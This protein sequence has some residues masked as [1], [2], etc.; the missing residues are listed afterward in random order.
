MKLIK[1][2][3]KKLPNNLFYLGKTEK[4]PYK[5]K[6]SGIFGLEL[7][8][9]DEIANKVRGANNGMAKA[10]IQYD[11]DLNKIKEYS[12]AREASKTLNI[13][14]SN[15]SSVCSGK[16]NSAGGFIWKYKNNQNNSLYVDPKRRKLEQQATRILK[17]YE[18]LEKWK[19]YKEDEK[20]KSNVTKPKKKI[21]SKKDSSKD[22]Q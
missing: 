17:A 22:L 4:D 1:I 12:T 10:V 11:K 14:F 15:T 20:Y 5:Y 3:V 18:V 9:K 8:K 2:Y 16:R 19:Q 21:F 6:G 13:D 7:L